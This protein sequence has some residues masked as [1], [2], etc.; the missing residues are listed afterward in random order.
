LPPR[1]HNEL[2]ADT[3]EQLEQAAHDGRLEKVPGVVAR[4]ALAIKGALADRL[5]HRHFRRPPIQVDYRWTW[6]GNT[7]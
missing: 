4:R 6:T 3:L 7:G 1:I 5:G 2:N